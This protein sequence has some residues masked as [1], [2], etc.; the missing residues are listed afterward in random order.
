[1]NKKELIQ[2]TRDQLLTM[3]ERLGVRG[4]TKMTKDALAEAIVKADRLGNKARTSRRV[5]DKVRTL[6]DRAAARANRRVTEKK[7]DSPA[8]V[9]AAASMD[10]MD[11]ETSKYEL[12]TESEQIDRG[13]IDTFDASE[14]PLGYGDDKI[15]LMVRDPYWLYSYWE[16]TA[17]KKEEI[18]QTVG[19]HEYNGGKM[20]LRIYDVTDVRFDGTNSHHFFDIHVGDFAQNW[21]INAPGANRAYIADLGYLTRSGQFVLIARSNCVTT[22]RDTFSDVVDE[23]W[24]IVEDDFLEMFRLSGGY[25]DAGKASE[26]AGPTPKLRLR[27]PHMELS[28]G[29]FSGAVSSLSSP[30]GKRIQREKTFWLKVWTELIVYGATEPDASVTVQGRPI[31]L[32]PDGTFTLRYELP[33][34]EQVIPVQATNSDGDDTR[35]ITPIVR[36][37]TR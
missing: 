23:E 33:D 30:F 2:K 21:Y 10:E 20:V 6:V 26:F 3:A 5:K 27:M 13:Q 18:R 9:M 11:V 32:R 22:P 31:Q 14:I 7:Y 12:F 15:V 35:T 36:K 25:A 17:G 16:V 29:V 8:E 24:M 28:S 19:D 34:G 37:E 4:R 1:M